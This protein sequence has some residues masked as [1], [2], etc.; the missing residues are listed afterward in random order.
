MQ[1]SRRE[2]R[3]R[4]STA[5]RQPSTAPSRATVPT[6][7]CGAPIQA[8]HRVQCKSARPRQWMSAVAIGSTR[9]KIVQSD[10][11]ICCSC[12]GDTKIGRMR[13]PPTIGA[14]AKW[15]R[16]SKPD[17]LRT[18]SLSASRF[19]KGAFFMK[20]A[21]ARMSGR[22]REHKRREQEAPKSPSHRRQ[23]NSC[24]ALARRL[25]ALAEHSISRAGPVDF[26]ASWKRGCAWRC[27][28]QRG[29]GR[30]K[31]CPENP[32]TP[33]QQVRNVELINPEHF[34]LTRST[35]PP[36]HHRRESLWSKFF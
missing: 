12:I 3:L 36:R 34:P 20:A 33:I 35:Q 32:G 10:E 17:G 18:S 11:R 7:R 9:P 8:G 24:L 25:T 1:S 27:S 15:T 13:S 21:C 26:T 23:I 4:L 28:A 31:N 16:G 22:R 14:S 30:A 29:V 19:I 5:S 6:W 2:R